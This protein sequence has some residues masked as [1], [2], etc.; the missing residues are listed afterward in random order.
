[1]ARWVDLAVPRRKKPKLTKADQERFLK[2]KH[3]TDAKIAKLKEAEELRMAK[4]KVYKGLDALNM[5]KD[6]WMVNLL[7]Y[8]TCSYRPIRIIDN[9]LF[10]LAE[11]GKPTEA[12]IQLTQ[13]LQGEYVVYAPVEEGDWVRVEHDDYVVYGKVFKIRDNSHVGLIGEEGTWFSLSLCTKVPREEAYTQRLTHLFRK[14]NRE[15]LEFRKG[16][17]V[18][19]KGGTITEVIKITESGMVNV[20]A[21][22]SFHDRRSLTIIAFAEDR[23]EI[24]MSVA[25]R[26]PMPFTAPT[27]RCN[28]MVQP[29]PCAAPYAPQQAPCNPYAQGGN[30]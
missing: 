28:E 20:Y 19:T 16:D 21:T 30:N 7:G 10:L 6:H 12:C 27:N 2:Q 29:D 22:Q 23:A 14:H 24:P 17:I 13:I 1:M 5:M 15:L 18:R 11:D 26:L 9:K 3:E 4:E 25:H 8:K